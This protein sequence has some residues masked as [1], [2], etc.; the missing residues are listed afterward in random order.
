MKY[1]EAINEWK[2]ELGERAIFLAGG[3]IGCGD[4]QTEMVDRLSDTNLIVLNPRRNNFPHDPYATT[5][6]IKW[7][8]DN[9]RAADMVMFW[10]PKEG[11]CQ[12]SLYE[13][14]SQVMMNKPL[15][16]GVEPGYVKDGGVRKQLALARPEIPV[17]NNLEDLELLIKGSI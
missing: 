9:L 16:V 2:R 7:E 15:F 11:L 1:V 12:T 8:F 5:I 10:F 14:G 3:I 17:V 13:L 6:Q 4:W